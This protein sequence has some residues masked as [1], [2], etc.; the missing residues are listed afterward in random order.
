V[1]ELRIKIRNAEAAMI[2]QDTAERQES[3]IGLPISGART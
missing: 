3:D 2:E 1:R